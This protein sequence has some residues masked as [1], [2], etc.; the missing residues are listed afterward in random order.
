MIT[1]PWKFP[2]V[3]NTLCY[4]SFS[5]NKFIRFHVTK[6]Q[7][8]LTGCPYDHITYFI[9]FLNLFDIIYDN[10]IATIKGKFCQNNNLNYQVIKINNNQNFN[11]KYY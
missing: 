5:G 9:T 6:N 8:T 4:K 11:K 1:F 7:Y 3:L 10:D 2:L